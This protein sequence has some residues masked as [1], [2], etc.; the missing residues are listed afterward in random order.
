MH[1]AH[2]FDRL[3]CRTRTEAAA[4]LAELGELATA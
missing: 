4:K 3:D 2:L 1:V